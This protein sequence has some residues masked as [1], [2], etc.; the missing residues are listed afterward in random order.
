MAFPK[1]CAGQD[2]KPFRLIRFRR[3]TFPNSFLICLIP[4]SSR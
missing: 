3:Y 2:E 1:T 4:V